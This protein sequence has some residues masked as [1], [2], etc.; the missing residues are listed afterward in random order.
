MSGSACS[1]KTYERFRLLQA[2]RFGQ[3]D[4]GIASAQSRRGRQARRE[5]PLDRG[6][7]ALEYRPR[8]ESARRGCHEGHLGQDQRTHGHVET[9]LAISGVAPVDHDRTPRSHHHVQ[10]VQIH[11]DDA[12][13][14]SAVSPARNLMQA[15][16]EV[17]QHPSGAVD[18]ELT[19]LDRVGHCRAVNTLH[20]QI[21]SA[22]GE[23]LRDRVAV[24]SDVA[25]DLRLNRRIGTVAIASK[26]P[27]VVQSEDIGVSSSG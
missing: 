13:T 18:I 14:A 12:L 25:H 4:V 26:N 27:A 9:W 21:W 23:D 22:G 2:F 16:V 8:Q 5:I 3:G 24:C 20:H 19:A 11:M 15:V 17:G 6:D 7:E 1:E 10:G